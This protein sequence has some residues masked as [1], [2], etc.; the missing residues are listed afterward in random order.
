ME[1]IAV[2]VSGSSLSWRKSVGA[3]ASKSAVQDGHLTFE[4][5][6]YSAVHLCLTCICKYLT[7][8]SKLYTNTLN[9]SDQ[10]VSKKVNVTSTNFMHHSNNIITLKTDMR[11]I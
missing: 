5:H 6:N 1:K 3:T 9:I 7:S 2:M 11:L 8:S 10:N 4:R